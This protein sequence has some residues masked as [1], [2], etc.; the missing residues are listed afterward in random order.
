MCGFQLR[1]ELPESRELLLALKSAG[2]VIL[3]V[4]PLGEGGAFDN[5]TAIPVLI[6]DARDII[7]TTIAEVDS[8]AERA[9]QTS[10]DRA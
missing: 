1:F 7:K 5:A 6:P 3:A 8:W 9:D 2:R 4:T 10:E